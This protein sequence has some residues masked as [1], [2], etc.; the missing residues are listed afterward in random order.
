MVYLIFHIVILVIST[1]IGL[2]KNRG[3]TGFF[4]GLVLG[5]I[6]LIIT[7]TLKDKSEK[8]S[9]KL[10]TSKESKNINCVKANII[11]KRNMANARRFLFF[12][13]LTILIGLVLWYRAIFVPP[14]LDNIGIN[15]N[16][17]IHWVLVGLGGAIFAVTPFLIIYLIVLFFSKNQ[18]EE[19]CEHYGIESYCSNCNNRIKGSP[20]YCPYCHAQFI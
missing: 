19:F 16:N 5:P 11:Y 2:N 4:L 3:G 17:P 15:W 1:L 8:S 7:L 6:G 12:P 10:K 18:W 20:D 13:I 14:I 9:F